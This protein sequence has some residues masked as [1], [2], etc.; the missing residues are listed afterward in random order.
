M[1]PAIRPFLAGNWKMN[2]TSDSLGELRAI[3]H[4][5]MSGLDADTQAAICVPATLLA[6]AAGVLA[7][8]PVK[9]G[10]QHC[11]PAPSGPYTGEI[12]AEMLKDAGASYVIAGHSECRQGRSETDAAV[13]EQAEAA[14]RAGL[15]AIIC[16]GETEAE[17]GAGETLDVLARQVAGSVPSGAT[18]ADTILAYEPIWAIGSGKTP[19]AGEVA[20]AHAHIRAELAKLVG[21]HAARM[22]ILYGGSAKPAN[23]VEI[24]SIANVDGLLVGGAS[25]KAAEFLA[26]AE[27]YRSV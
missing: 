22:P 7:Q 24:I 21:A 14:H 25:L 15:I 10:G 27:A 19:T 26:I 11:H 9:V 8:T 6:R 23:A 17:H 12:S 2:G 20:E 5:F 16:I 18:A 4:G 13:R 1:T 3:G